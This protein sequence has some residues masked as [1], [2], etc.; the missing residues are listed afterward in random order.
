MSSH[1]VYVSI[2]LFSKVV[3]IKISIDFKDRAFFIFILFEIFQ[4]YIQLSIIYIITCLIRTN[5]YS[6]LLLSAAGDQNIFHLYR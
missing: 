6:S 4:D 3:F 2:R 1:T 5:Y